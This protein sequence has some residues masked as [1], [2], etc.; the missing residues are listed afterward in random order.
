MPA[1]GALA[2]VRELVCVGTEAAPGCGD[3]FECAR[4]PGPAP[5]R[6]PECR[7]IRRDEQR[8]SRRAEARKGLPDT[9]SCVD[10]GRPIEGYKPGS[11]GGVPRRCRVHR[12]EREKAGSR[13]RATRSYERKKAERRSP[14][15]NAGIPQL[16]S[17]PAGASG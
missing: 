13:E 16:A 12:A 9:I 10:C 11:R 14:A 17:L 6:C 5:K 2:G 7:Q 15:G 3:T 1:E 8:L 4:K